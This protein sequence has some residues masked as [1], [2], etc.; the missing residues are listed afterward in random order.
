MNVD[1][2]KGR[3]VI[4]LPVVELVLAIEVERGTL[5][6][7]TTNPRPDCSENNFS[8]FSATPAGTL[9]ARVSDS[10][11]CAKTVP[12]APLNKQQARARKLWRMARPDMGPAARM[13]G[14]DDETSPP[15]KREL[16]I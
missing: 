7:A 1:F 6:A 2:G 5:C 12:P 16:L 13:V 11:D 15:G 14:L 4:N 10:G 8:V 3:P 9:N